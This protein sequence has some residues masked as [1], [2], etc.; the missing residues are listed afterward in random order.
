MRRIFRIVAAVLLAAFLIVLYLI[1]FHGLRVER[2]GSGLWLMFWFHREQPAAAVEASPA[3]QP[4]PPLPPPSSDLPKGGEPVK[5]PPKPAYWTD[6]RGPRRDGRYDEMPILTAWSAAGP[7]RLWRKPIGGGY[8][9]FVAANGRIFTV[10]QRRNQE[11]AAAYDLATG[12]EIWANG[13]EAHFTESMGGDG[14]RATPTWHDGRLY[15]LGAEGELRCLDAATG[16]LVWSKNILHDNGAQNLQW[17]MSA[18]PLVVDD[19]LIVLPGGPG[20]KS[21]VAYDKL[22]GNPIWRALDDKQAYTSPMLVTLAGERQIIVVTALRAVGL[23]TGGRLLWE[24]PWR[25]EYDINSAQPVI[26]GPD[27]FILSAAY[28]HGAALVRVERSG[29]TW[30]ASRVWENNRMKNKFTSSVLHE[31]YLYGLDEAILACLN[32][33]T[34][35][36]KWKGGRYGYGQLILANGH[37]IVTAED[38]DVALVRAT[39][40]R[41]QELVRFSAIRGK[42]WNHPAITD[43]I[44][45]VRNGDEMS[46]FQLKR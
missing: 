37:L 17:G 11:V 28:G 24:Y 34:G 32:A 27:R 15:A 44:L 5:T 22:T 30:R 40:D 21:V 31:G 43:G 42:T 18:S 19:R 2:D 8:A 12:R 39:P 9:S 41:H 20:G 26:A 6:F 46:A 14:P 16:R 33:E 29:D 38:G 36:L 45:L 25:T 1:R 4:L 10:E 13:W 7:A 35:E 3:P 23:T